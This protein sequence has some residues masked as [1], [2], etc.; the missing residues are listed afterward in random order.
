MISGEIEYT[1]T[2]IFNQEINL[3][4]SAL[5]IGQAISLK[6]FNNISIMQNT[7]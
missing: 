6:K 5:I 3:F 1:S 4:L 7:N 2:V